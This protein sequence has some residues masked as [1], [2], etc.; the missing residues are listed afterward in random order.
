MPWTG[1]LGME[2]VVLPIAVLPEVGLFGT[3]RHFLLALRFRHS[4]KQFQEHLGAF[5]ELLLSFTN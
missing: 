5:T 1:L 3:L 2:I 4:M